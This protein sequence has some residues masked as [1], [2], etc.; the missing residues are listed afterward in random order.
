MSRNFRQA[1]LLDAFRFGS[2]EQ[3]LQLLEGY[4][5]IR[6]GAGV[7]TVTAEDGDVFFDTTSRDLYVRENSAWVLASS[8]PDLAGLVVRQLDALPKVAEYDYTA[9]TLDIVESSTED[10]LNSLGLSV[11]FEN[12]P[13][14]NADTTYYLFNTAPSPLTNATAEPDI[15]LTFPRFG[16]S[17]ALSGN[18]MSYIFNIDKGHEIIDAFVTTAPDVDLSQTS[19]TVGDT[20]YNGN[21]LF[22][23]F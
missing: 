1:Q 15:I 7:P 14:I 13:T 18:Q 11:V 12:A 17:S 4:T 16:Y 23:T 9:S 21:I 22:G 10:F 2:D 6:S 20:T 5:N 3:V 19:V 8:Q